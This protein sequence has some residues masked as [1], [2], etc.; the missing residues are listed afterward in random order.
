MKN[1]RSHNRVTLRTYMSCR[2]FKQGM[3]EASQG[4]PFNSDAV[5]FGYQYRYERGRLFAVL[6]KKPAHNGRWASDEAMAAYRQ[7]K[8]EGS[9]F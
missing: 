6:F 4:R 1:A 8:R 7:Y 2:W 5:P 3:K 9:I